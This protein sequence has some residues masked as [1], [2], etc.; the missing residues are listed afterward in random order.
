MAARELGGVVDPSL[1][2]YGTT[3]LRVVDASVIPMAL[4]ANPMATVYAFAEKVGTPG[5]QRGRSLEAYDSRRLQTSSRRGSEEDGDPLVVHFAFI[6]R[7][8]REIN[9]TA[10]TRQRE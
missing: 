2:V 7:S 4:G 5:N 1:K 6:H 3:N 9:A 10:Q 8:S